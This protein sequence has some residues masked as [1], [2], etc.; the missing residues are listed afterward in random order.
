MI[1]EGDDRLL[2]SDSLRGVVPEL[3]EEEIEK[4]RD[5]YIVISV[6][7]SDPEEF[8]LSGLCTGIVFEPTATKIDIKIPLV[9]GYELLMRLKSGKQTCKCLYLNRGKDILEYEGPY[10]VVSPRLT[11][12]DRQTAM[13]NL[14]LDLT[15]YE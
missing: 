6:D 1:D 4:Y 7:L 2:M 13:C 3:E 10:K 9:L 15:R 11:D 5:S 12:F 8:I 14:G